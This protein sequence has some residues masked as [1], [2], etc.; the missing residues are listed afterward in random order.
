MIAA[1]VT[2]AGVISPGLYQLNVIVPATL[3]DGD[4]ALSASYGGASAPVGGLIAVKR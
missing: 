1:T 4:A 3:A 2:F